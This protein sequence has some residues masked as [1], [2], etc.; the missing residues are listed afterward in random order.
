MIHL[1]TCFLFPLLQKLISLEKNSTNSLKNK[2]NVSDPIGCCLGGG[3]FMQSQRI[4]MSCKK[5]G[6][7]GRKKWRRKCVS[8]LHS[9]Q[10]TTCCIYRCRSKEN[11]TDSSSRLW[12]WVFS[13][14]HTSKWFS[15]MA[16][17]CQFS[18]SCNKFYRVQEVIS[19]T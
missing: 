12:L 5:P 10:F 16:S 4:E 15:A 7:L 1:L 11:F 8:A 2:T 14:L 6:V 17:N 3:Y 9:K 19:D 18:P 13:V